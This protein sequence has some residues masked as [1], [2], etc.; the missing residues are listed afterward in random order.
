MFFKNSSFVPAKIDNKTFAFPL[1]LAETL[2]SAY[3]F[4]QKLLFLQLYLH[5]HLIVLL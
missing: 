4:T 5:F 2:S 3:G 1:N